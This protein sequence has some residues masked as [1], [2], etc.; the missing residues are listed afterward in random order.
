MKVGQLMKQS[1]CSCQPYDSLNTAAQIMWEHD[2]GCVPV[3][4][5]EGH[6]VAVVTD[7]D[8]CMSAFFRGENLHGL[9]VADAMSKQVATCRETDTVADAEQT[10]R[11]QQVRR[12]PVVDEHNVLVG[13]L[14]LGDI[15]AEAGAETARSKKKTKDVAFPEVG[16]TLSAIAQ[17]SNSHAV[18][19]VA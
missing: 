4:D 16:Q 8:I 17:P 14:S 19:T 3:V 6:P 7:R 5:H 10:M 12:L 18:S 11:Q 1:V 9:C 2:C 13:M 15:A